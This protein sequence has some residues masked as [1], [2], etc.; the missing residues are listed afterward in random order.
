M[1]AV[2]VY[3]SAVRFGRT[4]TFC[5]ARI[6]RILRPQ[7]SMDGANIEP[8]GRI[9]PNRRTSQPRRS[10]VRIRQKEIRRARKRE[11]DQLHTRIKALKA[12]KA[13]TRPQVRPSSRPASGGRPGAAPTRAPRPRPAAPAE[14]PAE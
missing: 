11:E 5:P 8:S 7:R 2:L 1:G 6:V 13:A 4:A 9:N 14:A 3:Y 12:A 10:S